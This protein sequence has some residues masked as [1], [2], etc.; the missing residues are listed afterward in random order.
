MKLY[1][2]NSIDYNN[3]DNY[4]ILNNNKNNKKYYNEQKL[5]G[6]TLINDDRN[7]ERMNMSIINFAMLKNNKKFFIK[8]KY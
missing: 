1:N 4:I 7:K 2:A 8:N 5:N 6:K 3:N